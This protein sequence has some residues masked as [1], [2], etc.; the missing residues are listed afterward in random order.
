MFPF[1]CFH[2]HGK[3]CDIL[4]NRSTTVKILS[5][6]LEGGRSVKKSIEID[7]HGLLGGG[8][9]V[10]SHK[11]DAWV[12]WC[13]NRGHMCE[14]NLRQTFASEANKINVSLAQWS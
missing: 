1:A 3:K 14:R 5:K 11:D 8:M 2:P 6:P 9:V 12:F 10:E 4:V 13:D 7:C